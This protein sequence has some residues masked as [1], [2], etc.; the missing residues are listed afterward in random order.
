MKQNIKINSLWTN[1]QSGEVV[2]V[3]NIKAGLIKFRFADFT[4]L[5]VAQNRFL[6][7]YE[8]LKK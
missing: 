7:I 5:T 3:L 2:K 4:E 8:E 6:K 1:R